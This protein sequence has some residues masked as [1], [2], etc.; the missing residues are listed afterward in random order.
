[1]TTSKT[2][3]IINKYRHNKSEQTTKK[4]PIAGI[5]NIVKKLQHTKS[6]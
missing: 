1:M 4:L 3:N 5:L 6:K 2:T